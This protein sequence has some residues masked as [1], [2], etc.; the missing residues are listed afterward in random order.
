MLLFILKMYKILFF[1]K[2]REIWTTRKRKNTWF[3]EDNS[4]EERKLSSVDVELLEFGEEFSD[5]SQHGG[6]TRRPGISAAGAAVARGLVRRQERVDLHGQRPLEGA[7]QEY[8][9]PWLLEEND[10]ANRRTGL[11]WGRTWLVESRVL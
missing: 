1:P 3:E 8:L 11:V 4:F 10:L 2:I 9:R 6:A 5:G 7:Q